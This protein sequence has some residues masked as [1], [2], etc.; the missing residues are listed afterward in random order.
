MNRLRWAIAAGFTV[1]FVAAGA[2]IMSVHAQGSKVDA[3]NLLTGQ[4]AF[5]D[6]R[7]MKP[8]VFR[9]IT[10]ADLPKP[11][12]TE[13]SGNFPRVVARPADAWPQVPSGF[14]VDL[15]ASGLKGARQIRLA[16]NG[17]LFVTESAGNQLS[18]YRGRDKDGK[19]EVTSV[20][21]TG[22]RQPF[23]IAFYPPGPN[24]QWVYVGNTGSV[25]R[26][27]YK[28]GDVKASGEAQTII[29]ELPP[30]GGH[31]TR[32]VVFSPN[33]QR[34]WV[35]VGSGSN[36]DDPDTHPR[37]FHRA[38]ILEFKPDGTF[39]KIYASGIRN[40]VGLGVNPTTGELW[41]S[42]NERD[43]LGDNLVPDYVTH[44]RE[45]GFYGWPWYYMGDNVDPRLGDKHPELR[46]KAIVPD[47]LLSPHNA[48]LGLTFYDG[49]M[50]PA[51]YKGDL[52]A[53]EHGSW[54]RANRTGYEIIR[55]PLVNGK[56][57][58]EFED[59]MTGF[60]TADGSVWG[61]PVAVV[62]AKDGSL[63]VTDDGSQSIWRV[64]YGK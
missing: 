16:P 11:F 3:K 64:S 52:F 2:R 49:S 10:A 23:G 28:V 19:P 61:R 15:Y 24:P 40:P 13:S 30:G 35:A 9:K 33:G 7:T 47:V 34:M 55:V 14:K 54:N 41:C 17:D 39:V 20:F 8:G 37:E 43:A 22:L 38:N 53:A 25:V 58:G 29:A 21:A 50:F 42:T 12:A 63:L 59:F 45:D 62:T 27:P 57:S 31:W 5:I 56:A 46:A 1:L 32:D 18:V 36:I 6:Y 51:E 26:F 48:S 4:A 44:V 60:V